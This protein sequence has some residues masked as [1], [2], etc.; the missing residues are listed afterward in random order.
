MI[1]AAASSESII[2]QPDAR[3][4]G[5]QRGRVLPLPISPSEPDAI[6]DR[7]TAPLERCVLTVPRVSVQIDARQKQKIPARRSHRPSKRAVSSPPLAPSGVTPALPI[8]HTTTTSIAH[9]AP[10]R[11]ATVAIDAHHKIPQ[12]FGEHKTRPPPCNECIACASG[13]ATTFLR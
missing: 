4:I 5:R 13:D 2:D 3:S 11:S 1:A 8:R 12:G 7:C 6:P 9:A 10:P